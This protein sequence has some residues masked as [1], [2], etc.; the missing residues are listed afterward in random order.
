MRSPSLVR[1]LVL[2]SVVLDL[3]VLGR[4][5]RGTT[6]EPVV[7]LAELEGVPAEIVRPSGC[8]PWPAW[9][10]VNGAHPERRREPVVTRLSRGLARAGYLVVVPD[11]PGLGEG[12]I[13]H[14][15]V[16]AT[17]AV[18]ERVAGR[19][20]VAG[21]RVALIGASTGAGLALITAAQPELAGRVSVVAAVAPFADLEKMICLATTGGYAENGV[22]A[23]YEATDLH[24]RVVARSLVATIEG[25]ERVRLAAA[26]E[27]AEREGLDPLAALAFADDDLSVEARAVLSLL[28]NDD[29]ARFGDLYLALPEPALALLRR[30]SPLGCCHDVRAPVELVVPPADAYFPPGEAEALAAALPDVR[31]TVTGTLDHTRPKLSARALRDARTFGGFVVRG[32]AA[33]G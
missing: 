28:R 1:A 20:D 4:A 10:F 5:V 24:R 33:A 31:L 18:T 27:Q 3:P 22:F 30:L 32:L 12:E 19:P 21:N 8:G 25:E 29:A 14:R 7:E 26:L 17:F 2:L 11:L 13:T 16:E 6:G 23:R 9:L 15:T